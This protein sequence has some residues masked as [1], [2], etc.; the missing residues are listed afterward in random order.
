M[1]K[2]VIISIAFIMI[3]ILI[4][5]GYLFCKKEHRDNIKVN[6]DNYQTNEVA[7]YDIQSLKEEYKNDDI[8]GILSIKNTELLVPIAQSEDNEYYLER[9]L[10]K[11]PDIAGSIFLD[12]RFSIEDS[13]KKIIYGHNNK[14]A[15]TPFTYLENYYNEEFYKEHKYINVQTVNSTKTYEI[16]SVYVEISNWDYMKDN[17]NEQEWNEHLQELKQNS[18]YSTNVDIKEDDKILILQTC[19]T[20]E[21]YKNY[22]DKYLLIISKEIGG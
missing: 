17:Y 11:E 3:F 16:F 6:S 14:N 1:K 21:K 22:S 13:R 20:L 7:K 15:D 18:I 8:I 10:Y 5:I 12:Y 19:S 2:R 9:N 4:A